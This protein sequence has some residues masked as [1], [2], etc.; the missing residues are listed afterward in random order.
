LLDSLLQEMMDAKRDLA[1]W[2][3]Q[4]QLPPPLY[5]REAVGPSTQGEVTSF[6]FCLANGVKDTGAGPSRE[7]AQQQ[8][9]KKVLCNLQARAQGRK[10]STM[11]SRL[12]TRRISLEEPV[13]FLARIAQDQSFQVS[14]NEFMDEGKGQFGCLANINTGNL[15]TGPQVGVCYGAGQ[16]QVVAREE[17]ARSAL[18]Y[19]RVITT[20]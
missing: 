3:W 19:L 10:T 4:H 18:N 9:A 14:Y 15:N 1:E 6:M 16:D 11:I 13:S 7:E 2:C 5:D 12:H 8:A 20:N 17:A